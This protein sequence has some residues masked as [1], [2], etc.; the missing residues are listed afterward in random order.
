MAW[1][2]FVVLQIAFVA[3]GIRQD[4]RSGLWSSGLFGFCLAF[5]GVETAILTVPVFVLGMES[6]W[7]G[8]VY[9]ASWGVAV[10]NFG[11]FLRVVRRWGTRTAGRHVDGSDEQGAQDSR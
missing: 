3:A 5:A 7:F 11:W 9:G 10:L 2:A 1:L 6:R 8:W 4:Q